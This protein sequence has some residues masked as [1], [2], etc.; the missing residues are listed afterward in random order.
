MKQRIEKEEEERA[1]DRENEEHVV[2]N[3]NGGASLVAQ[4]LRLMSPIQGTWVHFLIR[5]LDLTCCS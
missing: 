3:G 5:E 1:K 2:K 4:W